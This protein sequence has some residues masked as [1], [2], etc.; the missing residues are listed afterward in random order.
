M[1]RVKML[2][3]SNMN[4]KKKKKKYTQTNCGDLFHNVPT[5]HVECCQECQLNV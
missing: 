4:L 3:K 1:P 2:I 5:F